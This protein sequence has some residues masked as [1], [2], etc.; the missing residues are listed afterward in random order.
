MKMPIVAGGA[1][2]APSYGRL[3]GQGKTGGRVGCV[4]VIVFL[5]T[6]CKKPRELGTTTY[7]QEDYCEADT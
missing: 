2:A 1:V 6:G 3:N 4:L 5:H 7:E